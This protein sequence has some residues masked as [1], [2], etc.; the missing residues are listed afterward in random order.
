MLGRVEQ[1]ADHIRGQTCPANFSFLQQTSRRRR[2]QLIERTLDRVVD[3]GDE[4]RKRRRRITRLPFGTGRGPLGVG[5]QFPAR[6]RQETVE[7]AAS[8]ADMKRNRGRAARALPHMPGWNRRDQPLQIFLYLNE[9][10]D[11]GHD[12]WLEPW[13]GPALPRF[14]VLRNRHGLTVADPGRRSLSLKHTVW[15][16]T[17]GT[18]DRPGVR[19]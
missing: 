14:R 11:D 10:M 13:H 19:G 3:I 12:Q 18:G 6:V 15:M 8:V 1:Q 2:A 16:T 5:Q 9:G 17:F 7:R 4:R